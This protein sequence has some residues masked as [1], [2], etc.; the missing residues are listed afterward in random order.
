MA[1]GIRNSETKEALQQNDLFEIGGITKNFTAVALMLLHEEGKIE[2][3][4]TIDKWFPKLE[5]SDEITVRMLLNHTSGIVEIKGPVEPSEIVENVSGRFN[6]EPGTSWAPSNSNYILAGLIIGSVAEKPAHEVIREK[7]LTPLGMTHTFMKGYED[8]PADATIAS[9]HIFDNHG[10]LVP[11]E[12]TDKLWTAGGLVSNAEDL[13]KYAYALFNKKILSEDSMIEMAKKEENAASGLGIQ[14]GVGT[15]GIFY[16]HIGDAFSSNS[17]LAYYPGS[18]EIHIIL[19]NFNENKDMYILNDEIEWVL[20]DNIPVEKKTSLPDWSSLTDTDENTQVFALYSVMNPYVNQFQGVDY[21]IGYF[22]YPEDA[23]PNYYCM[24]YL[25][26]NVE[27]EFVRISQE[28]AEPKEYYNASF[29]LQR[30]DIYITQEVFDKAVESKEAT[31]DFYVTKYDYFYDPVEEFVYKICYNF[32]DSGDDR[33]I[34]IGRD[35]NRAQSEFYYIWGKAKMGESTRL[36]GCHCYKKAEEDS[37]EEYE[38][39]E[40]EVEEN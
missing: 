8:A 37:V 25:L 16:G 1:Y 7:I 29:K 40:E 2:L 26:K 28:C 10:K 24:Q 35:P 9:G 14:Y 23:Y 38:C 3:D 27:P 36:T 39:S 19:N 15:H 6:F 5:K 11:S 12:N 22:S 4:Q 31:K 33:Q 32:E 21:G 13:F 20:A 30:T 18:R 34:V 17:L